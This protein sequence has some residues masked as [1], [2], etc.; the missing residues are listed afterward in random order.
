MIK[1]VLLGL[2]QGITEF[3]P[4][5][6]SGHLALFHHLLGYYPLFSFDVLAHFGT[7]MAILWFFRLDLVLL[8]RGIF[9]W[10]EKK[11]AEKQRQLLTRLILASLPVLLVGLLFGEKVSLA[12]NSPRLVAIGFWITALLLLS[13]RFVRCPVKGWRGRLLGIGLFQ[14]LSIMPGISR[15]ASTI[16]SARILGEEKEEAFRL[17]FL[18]G[19]IAIGAAVVYEIPQLCQ[20][21]IG[22]IKEGLLVVLVSFLAGLVALKTLYRLFL[23]DKMW[24]LAFYC[25]LLGTIIFFFL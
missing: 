9:N 17:S 23:I 13:G 21:N 15:S 11:E 24:Y 6:S 4:I 10:T 12:F 25:L 1:V 19:L 7:L 14:A 18:L 5:S 3:L 22:Q 16:T 2:V 8:V 20:F